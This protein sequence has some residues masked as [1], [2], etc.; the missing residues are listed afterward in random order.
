MGREN[1]IYKRR[2]TQSSLTLGDPA[3]QSKHFSTVIERTNANDVE[4]KA[5]LEEL[6]LNLSRDAVEADM[7]LGHHWRICLRHTPKRRLQ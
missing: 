1:R 6:A 3:Q 2:F 5:T 7:A 4:L